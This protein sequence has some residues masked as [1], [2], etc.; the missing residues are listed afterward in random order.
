VEFGGGNL[1]GKWY[2]SCDTPKLLHF[3]FIAFFLNCISHVF[4]FSEKWGFYFAFL[5]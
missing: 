1:G 5:C 3:F 2:R 4:L